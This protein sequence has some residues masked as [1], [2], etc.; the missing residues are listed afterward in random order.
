[1]HIATTVFL[2]LFVVTLSLPL[3][4]LLRVPLP[5]LQI[6]L[7][8]GV[9]LLGVH[10]HFEPDVFMLLFIP[11][12][13]FSEAYLMPVRELRALGWPILML[14]FGLVLFT[15]VGCGTFLHWLIPQMQLAVCFA[16][17]AV[18]SPTDAVAVGGMLE[19]RAVPQRFMHIL[20]GEALLNDASGLVCFKFAVAAAMTGSFSLAHASGAFVVMSLAGLAIGAVLALILALGVRLLVRHGREDGIGAIMIPLLLP[21]AAY[22]G[23][24]HLGASGILAAVSAGLTLKQSRVINSTRHEIRL[25]STAVW[26]ILITSFNGLIF[27]LLGLE[28]PRLARGGHALIARVGVSPARLLLT[29]LV[30]TMVLVALRFVW[31]CFSVA[32]RDAVRFTRGRVLSAPRRAVSRPQPRLVV[33]MSVAG[34]RGAITLAAVLSLGDDFPGR[35]AVVTLAVGVIL[36][37]LLLAATCLPPLLR[38]VEVPDIDHRQQEVDRARL[39]VAQVAIDAAEHELALHEDE[40]PAG[41]DLAPHADADDRHGLD[42]LP[43]ERRTVLSGVLAEFQARELRLRA[44]VDPEG[45]GSEADAVERTLRRHRLETSFRL[46]VLRLERHALERMSRSFEIND[47]TERALGRE[48]DFQEE[49]LS[50]V[51]RSLPRP[52]PGSTGAA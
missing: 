29:I 18:L 5:L 35:D 26:S 32:L 13:L 31:I 46:R 28:L 43:E 39:A 37:S 50:T 19:G 2:L 40:E 47:E 27:L 42:V 24:E 22:L 9:S 17:A 10:V 6:A 4:A 8:V 15:T 3:A 30:I 33:A 45:C 41:D 51:A 7:G 38:G 20:S 16:L 23:A 48:L 11:P 52:T 12:L 36:A 25:R 14:A 34:V 21:F 49:V 44:V 1:M